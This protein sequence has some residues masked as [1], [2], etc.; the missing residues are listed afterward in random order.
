MKKQIPSG[1]KTARNHIGKNRCEHIL[2]SKL[3]WAVW[4]ILICLTVITAVVA[5][6]DLKW[7][8]SV[9]AL[10]IAT[11]K[12]TIVVLFFMHV[13]Y[14]SEKLTTMVIVS[15]LFWLLILLVLS[16][17]DYSTRLIG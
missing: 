9:A 11:G 16:L 5:T 6:L 3:Y 7:F 13:K 14:T 12:A 15:A 2:S 10:L 17:A 4:V 1:L 8:N